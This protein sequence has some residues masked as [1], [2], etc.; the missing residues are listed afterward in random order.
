[1]S[2]IKNIP[3]TIIYPFKDIKKSEDILIKTHVL[4]ILHLFQS[5]FVLYP[6]DDK[7]VS[8]GD[9]FTNEVRSIFA[10][11]EVKVDNMELKIPDE[12]KHSFE[13]IIANLLT[14]GRVSTI[15]SECGKEYCTQD[16]THKHWKIVAASLSGV[17]G[18]EILC[19]KGHRVF[20]TTDWRS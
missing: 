1:M 11:S 4:D 16:L 9:W 15:C 2:E 13:T 8:D 20:K 3:I 12:H 5:F 18:R 19:P 17:G 6:K 14:T 10:N 7:F